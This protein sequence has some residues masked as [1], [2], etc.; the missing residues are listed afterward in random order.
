MLSPNE[1]R[2]RCEALLRRAQAAG[3]ASGD[4]LYLAN[5]SQSVTV[6]LGALEDVE[7]SESEHIGLRVFAGSGSASIGSTDLGDAALDELAQRAVAMARL[8]PPDPY[9]G[10]ADEALLMPDVPADLDLDD[11][12]EAEPL[13]LRRMG[14][15]VEAAALAVSGV[16][17]S[18]GGSASS[19]RSVFALATSHG[20]AGAYAA[21]SHGLSASVLAGE[22]AT[23]QRDYAWRSTRHAADL[24][25]AELIGREAGERV[26]RRLNP[27]RVRSGPMTVVFDPRVG[28]S[29]VGHLIGAM[30]GAS[31]ARRASFLLDRDGAQLFDSA[32]TILDDPLVVRGLRSRPFDG[33]G[34]RT[35]PGALVEAGRLTGWLM[36][37]A[38][39]RQLGK[40]PS[41]HAGR[42]GSGAPH[43]VT[44]NVVLAAGP[45]S[46]AALMADIGEGVYV[47]ELIGSGV[48]GVTGDY[49]RGASGYRISGGV[50]GEPIAEFTVAGNLID[51]F[52]ALIP[53]NDLER[54]HGI[55]VPTIRIDGM[56]VAGD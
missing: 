3:A 54:I 24:P 32:V 33:E 38:A 34:L 10:L 1:A 21:S 6:R 20:F 53:A 2:D 52:A 41:G 9:A 18:N 50:I 4:A 5:S 31:I 26:T 46:P 29:L 40:A 56:T 51:M 28:A 12:G 30:N 16:T 15:A 42:G 17:N 13:A 49:S 25:A 37:S 23:M 7:R 36:D 19:G 47:T 35:A 22:G 43:V 44:G 39:A 48:N 27:G 11:G 14:E 8:A 45:L 55:D